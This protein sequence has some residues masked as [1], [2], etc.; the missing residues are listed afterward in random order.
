MTEDTLNNF[1]DATAVYRVGAPKSVENARETPGRALMPQDQQRLL[2]LLERTL[3]SGFKMAVIEVPSPVTRQAV[4]AWLQPHFEKLNASVVE[5]NVA[6]LSQQVGGKGETKINLWELLDRAIPRQS[7]TPL[8]VLT[9]FG[10]EDIMYQ[11]R[12]DRSELLQQ[13]NV[14]RDLLVRDFPCWWLLFIHPQSR[15]RWY[16]VAPD[17]CDFV[18][19]WVESALPET[20]SQ[21]GLTSRI[22]YG[23][24]SFLPSVEKWPADLRNANELVTLSEYDKAMDTLHAFRAQMEKSEEAE[25]ELAIAAMIETDILFI[26]GDMDAPLQRLKHS[27]LPVF[28]RLGDTHSYAIAMGRIADIL[29]QRGE[30]DEA[31]RIHREEELPVYERLGDVR[32]KAVTIGKITDILEQRGDTDEALRI[33]REEDLPVYERLGDARSKA[34]TMGNIADILEQ[35]GDT[36]EALRVLRT[37][38]LPAFERLGDARSKAVTMGK[39]AD[40]LQQR[41]ETDEALRIFLEEC[42]PIRKKLND[43]SGI[44]H[45]RYS[46]AQIRLQRGGLDKGE[47][48]TIFEELKES[49][50]LSKKLQRADSIAIV[51]ALYGQLLA[52]AGQTESALSVLSDAADACE[53]LGW[54]EQAAQARE[55][56]EHIRNMAK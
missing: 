50:A 47:A 41:G 52:A 54:P 2:R 49:F 53:K 33:H 37:E 23:P 46:C 14:Q 20:D 1:R 31:L 19:C 35:R 25:R 15:Q 7:R 43:I 12:Q 18:A 24:K 3:G 40:I 42:L 6:A 9:F 38:V 16:S 56:Q 29:E 8:Q 5:I 48:Q 11:G 27:I 39:I 45:I 10:F 22:D 51:G 30:L 4:M 13:I 44:A 28:E 36:D 32:S 17:F 55:I 26:R 21:R 34:V